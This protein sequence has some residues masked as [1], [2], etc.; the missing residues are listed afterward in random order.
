MQGDHSQHLKATV[1]ATNEYRVLGSLS[2]EKFKD[3]RI[4]AT[5]FPVRPSQYADIVISG[6][7][8][9]ISSLVPPSWHSGGSSTRLAGALRSPTF[10]VKHD[11]VHI[12]AMGHNSQI[13]IVINNLQIIRGPL[14]GGLVHNVNSTKPTWHKF[15]L[16]RWKGHR[17]YVELLQDSGNDNFIATDLVVLHNDQLPV[18]FTQQS[19]ESS[20]SYLE[21]YSSLTSLAE[22]FEKSLIH[23][24]H[25]W[26]NGSADSSDIDLLNF[27]L[28]NQLLK[29]VDNVQINLSDYIKLEE[30]IPEDQ[31]V[32]A[33]TD[34]PNRPGV[35]LSLIHI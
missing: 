30:L 34:G 16:S 29:T 2:G 31:R 17:A 7:D 12:R 25:R 11:F 6:I 9:H 24:F 5:A 13:R 20:L 27:F 28:S 21:S 19:S 10:D 22:N 8:R 18:K 4:E 23:T 3:W 35:V 33:M 1:N 14:H 26:Y 32:V 15:D